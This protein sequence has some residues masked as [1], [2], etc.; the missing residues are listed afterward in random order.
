MKIGLKASYRSFSGKKIRV[1]L[2]GTCNNSVW[3]NDLPML[4][5]DYYN[6][7]VP[8]WTPA[9]QQNELKER[10]SCDIVV[11]CITPAMT[12]VYSIAEVV[13]DSNKRPDKTVLCLLEQEAD[14]SAFS[15]YQ[16]KSLYAVCELVGKNGGKVCFSLQEVADYCNSF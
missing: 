14:R 15:K 1:F 16:L 5:T 6:P 2:G 13:D 3:R 8:D 9:F 12:G 10:S 7:V 11:Y 4:K